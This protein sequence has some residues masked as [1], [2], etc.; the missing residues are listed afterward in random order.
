MM[1]KHGK[2]LLIAFIGS[3]IGSAVG[4]YFIYDDVKRTMLKVNKRKSMQEPIEKFLTRELEQIKEKRVDPEVSMKAI[5]VNREDKQ[6]MGKQHIKPEGNFPL[7]PGS[8]GREV[9]RLQIWLQRN[10][11]MFPQ[12]GVYDEKTKELVKK[13]LK[14]DQVEKHVFESHNM[15]AH[16]TEQLMAR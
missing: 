11:G 15:G 3:L 14:S 8:T 6:Q 9:E 2:T 12:T 16:V 1:N 13:Y 7:I 5:Y 10:Y 4:V